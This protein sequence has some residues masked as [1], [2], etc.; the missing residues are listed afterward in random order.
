MTDQSPEDIPR[1]SELAQS[2][3]LLAIV[4]PLLGG[5]SA[6]VALPVGIAGL[7][8]VRRSDGR[9]RGAGHAIAAIVISVVAIVVT[10]G[11]ALY[12]IDNPVA[13]QCIDC[14]PME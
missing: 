11:G 10:V 4:S 3:L 8:E 2:A 13:W 14:Q 12:L 1:L 6:L 5:L 9:L 7:V